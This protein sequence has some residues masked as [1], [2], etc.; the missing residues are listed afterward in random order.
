MLSVIDMSGMSY[1]PALC[2]P[3]SESD[4]YLDNTSRTYM[5]GVYMTDLAYAALHGRH[6]AT[7]DYLDVVGSLSEEIRISEAVDEGL[8]GRVEE[9][10]EY[11]D[12]LYDISNEAFMNILS[13]C[14]RNEMPNTIVMMSAGAFI[15]SLY[16]AVNL[17]EDYD[18]AEDLLNHLAD[19][20]YSIDNFMAFAESV[21]E[22][23]PQISKTIE[24]LKHIN[25]IYDQI[26]TKSATL[27]VKTEK[28]EGEEKPKKLVI[29]SQ[30]EKSEPGLSEKEFNNLKSAV[31]E[32]RTRIVEG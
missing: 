31:I 26:E 11:L 3:A 7:I 18:M 21:K 17:I 32:L 14:D 25:E 20:K 22:D 24:D 12:S 16:L 30:A 27:T 2:S 19:Q 23:D 8:I 15:E 9:N 6:E 1:N 5:L 13:F 4:R 29:G 10:V 28:Q